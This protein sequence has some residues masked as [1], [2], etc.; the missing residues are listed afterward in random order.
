[1]KQLFAVFLTFF[2]AQSFGQ[3][4]KFP[5]L[6]N[7]YNSE[8]NFNGVAL[9]ATNG[10]IDYL[11]GIGISNRQ[12]GTIINSKAKFK[13][14]SVTKTFTA[15]MII[16]LMEEGKVNLNR[17]I[18]QYLPE[19]SGEA[20][21]RATI[22]NL[23]TYSS[24]IPNC[25]SYINDDIYL[26]PISMDSFIVKYCSGKLEA[27][28]GTKFNYDNGDYIIL[29]K[30]IEK[31]TGKTYRENLKERILGP[32]G[33]SNT[34]MLDSKDI[35]TGLVQ[36]YSFDDSLKTFNAD[37]PYYIEN[38]F[39]AGSMYST[40]EDLLKFDQGIFTFKLL[41]KETVDLMLTPH[42]KLENTGLG[43]WVSNK[44]GGLDTKFAY[45]PGGI[46]GARA[47]WIHVID[48]NRTIIVL[49]NTN[50][51]NL[52]EMSEQLNAIATNQ[53]TNIPESP[54]QKTAKKVDIEKLKG[55][56]VIDLRPGP[57]SEVYL[58]DLL[59]T[60]TKGDSFSGVFY[61]TSFTSGKVNTA[62]EFIYFAFTT[63]DREN[64]YYHSGYIDG[65]KIMG[66][67]YSADRNFISH[68]TGIKKI[69]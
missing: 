22:E 42:S 31:L 53:K 52:F 3:K 40:V 28:P 39:S 60:E 69:K 64:V 23:I 19:Y 21:D 65:D 7:Y 44:Y 34:D 48:S 4:D 11:K 54:K 46:Y 8:K 47:N 14:A 33:M 43:F 51:T 38:F 37:K 13:I 56:W 62:W 55:T 30:I 24:G 59:I 12:S 15:L 66:I 67:S 68:W 16:Q 9:V 18:G 35:V 1:M 5:K 20:K 26:K 63:H 45:R 32:L 6:L 36:S 58:Q 29:G 10:Q 50:A 49:S 2:A 41:K 25:E 61:G 17:T 57:N 27:A